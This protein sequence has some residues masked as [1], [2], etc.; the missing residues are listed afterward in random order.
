MSTPAKK[1]R[2]EFGQNVNE[3]DYYHSKNKKFFLDQHVSRFILRN[4]GSYPEAELMN[5]LQLIVNRAYANT[6]KE[7]R[8]PKQFGMML[9]GEGLNTPICIPARPA[10]QNTIDVIMNEIDMLEIR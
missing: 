2:H 8:E 6:R 10:E 4:M 9:F 7:G 1:F 5:I 3:I